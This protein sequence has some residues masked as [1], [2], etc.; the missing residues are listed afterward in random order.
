[1]ILNGYNADCTARLDDFENTDNAIEYFP[2][3]T[4]GT[5]YYIDVTEFISTMQGTT[6]TIGFNLISN[7][8]DGYLDVRI[9]NTAERR[10]QLRVQ[11][12]AKIVVDSDATGNNDGTS[13]TDA[14]VSLQDALNAAMAGDQ[15]WVAAGTY[16]PDEGSDPSSATACR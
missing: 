11:Y 6:G 5:D 3:H 9:A 7:G 4:S 12:A 1:M 15:I 13:W 14:Y 10:S 8:S 16:Y 2:A